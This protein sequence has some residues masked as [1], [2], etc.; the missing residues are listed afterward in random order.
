MKINL[1]I[2]KDIKKLM[3]FSLIIL[4]SMVIIPIVIISKPK[5]LVDNKKIEIEDDEKIAIE[6]NEKNQL[7]TLNKEEDKVTKK[8][9]NLNIED[10]IKVYLRDESQIIN[11]PIDEYIKSV[12]SGEMPVSFEIEA[13]K[14]QSVAARTFAISKI[15][16]PCEEANGADVC[17]STHCQVYL[18]KEVRLG[19]WDENKEDEYWSKIEMAVEGTTNEVLT[20]KNELVKYPQFFSTSSG[21][22]EN[23][24][25]VFVSQVEYLVSVESKGEEIAPRYKE[26]FTL[27]INDFI[28]KINSKYGALNLTEANLNENIEIISRSQGGGVKEI[29]IGEE[30]IKG[31]ELRYYLGLTSTNFEIEIKDSEIIFKCTGYGHGVGMS[32]W[33][34]NIMGQKGKNYSD[35]LKHY[36][37][38]I[39]IKEISYEN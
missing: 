32:Q 16:T 9:I 23:S 2:D 7:P 8:E 29:R 17:D 33:G 25:D 13:L 39:D 11:L 12:V 31:T 26:N 6:D 14:A 20:Y 34:A 37:T 3:F 5:A 22:T 27:S 18:D 35:I 28:K 36:Y 30:V 4:L 24:G 1:K 38:G 10:E 15:L 21:K 19:L